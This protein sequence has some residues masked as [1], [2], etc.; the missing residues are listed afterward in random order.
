[1]ENSQAV[2]PGKEQRMKYIEK[3]KIEHPDC[4]SDEY[5]GGC[6]GCPEDYAYEPYRGKCPDGSVTSYSE[7]VCRKCWERSEGE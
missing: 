7:E 2:P 3:L 5:F 4:V 1:M 6:D